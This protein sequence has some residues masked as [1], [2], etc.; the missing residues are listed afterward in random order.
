MKNNDFEMIEVNVNNLDC[1]INEILVRFIEVLEFNIVVK[2]FV[3]V[4]I[5]VDDYVVFVIVIMFKV[6]KTIISLNL[7]F[8]YIIGKGILVI[9]R[10]L[11]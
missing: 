1:I 4:N 2:V 11:F 6:N 10:V 9:F 8:N 7:D 3:L 5:R